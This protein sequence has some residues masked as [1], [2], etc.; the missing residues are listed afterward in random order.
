MRSL[1]LTG[2]LQALLAVC[3]CQSHRN[4][5]QEGVSSAGLS[6]RCT[7]LTDG[8]FIQDLGRRANRNEDMT[9]SFRGFSFQVSI[10]FSFPSWISASLSPYHL[11]QHSLTLPWSLLP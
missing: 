2:Q 5:A 1:L 11:Q 4:K 3:S 8:V 7:V 10:D 9:A 6:G